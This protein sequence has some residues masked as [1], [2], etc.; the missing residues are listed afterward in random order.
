MNELSSKI[1]VAP[2]SN[3][4]AGTAF[5]TAGLSWC[6]SQ[7]HGELTRVIKLG[8]VGNRRYDGGGVDRTDTGY[9][10][11]SV[12]VGIARRDLIELSVQATDT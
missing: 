5:T 11:E 7:P 4:E 1:A 10:P 2:F 9:A 3:T 12:A 6:E 8:T